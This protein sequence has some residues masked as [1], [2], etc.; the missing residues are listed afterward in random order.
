MGSWE[1]NSAGS[2]D[3]S[4]VAAWRRGQQ[5]EA[6]RLLYK[7]Y[8]RKLSYFFSKKGFSPE[9][10]HDLN[11]GTFLR[12]FNSMDSYR[13]DGPFRAWLFRIALNIYRNTLRE[14]GTQKRDAQE[15]PLDV[16]SEQPRSVDAMAVDDPPLEQ[17]LEDERLAKLRE[18]MDEL[19][20]QMRRCV[21]LRVYQDLSYREIAAILGVS[22][23]TVKAHLYQAR[24][25]LR[26]KLAAYFT[27]L[28][29]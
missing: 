16:A 26:T 10:C 19:P 8:Y 20:P 23:D 3:D 5:E 29:F 27:D 12:V 13:S 15:I 18:A 4:I 21:Q 24:Q 14:R 9:E 22:I 17:L 2:D 11:Q 6:F 25:Q 7:G 1:D 28:Q